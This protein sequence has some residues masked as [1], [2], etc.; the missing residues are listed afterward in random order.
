MVFERAASLKMQAAV[1]GAKHD[2]ERPKT[3]KFG[4]VQIDSMK[5]NN[6]ALDRRSS[7]SDFS[8]NSTNN[9][10]Y[11]FY[12]SK[13]CFTLYLLLTVFSIILLFWSILH[14]KDFVMN[15]GFILW[16]VLISTILV[17]DLCIKLYMN[18]S[19]KFF[20]SCYNVFDFLLVCILVGFYLCIL[21]LVNVSSTSLA[22]DEGVL[23]TLQIIWW[24]FQICRIFMLQNNQYGTRNKTE[25]VQLAKNRDGGSNPERFRNNSIELQ[26]EEEP[27]HNEQHNYS[28]IKLNLSAD[29]KNFEALSKYFNY[30]WLT[31]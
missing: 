19:K 20:K 16:E 25:N 9:R 10:L 4:A 21:F 17:I 26:L 31:T 15:A 11:R 29:V 8:D 18:G 22:Y 2:E 13:K 27:K 23:I 30:C 5:L 7:L 14:P 28:D 3:F 24:I 12:H 6:P 1:P